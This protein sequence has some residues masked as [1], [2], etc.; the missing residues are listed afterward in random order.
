MRIKLLWLLPV[1]LISFSG[2]K[3]LKDIT[4]G[5]SSWKA[6]EKRAL[7]EHLDFTAVTLSGKAR[8]NY[9]EGGFN[10]LGAS[11]RIT[12]L[13]DSVIMIRVIKLI[14]AAR[15]LITQDSIYV[16][17]RI[18]NQ[19]IV[20]DFGLAE[21]AIGLPADFGLIQDLL[22]G[23]YHP[24][25]SKM[26]PVQKRGNPKTFQGVAAGMNFT[27]SL[28]SDLAKPI[29]ILAIDPVAERNVSLAYADFQKSDYG[30][31]PNDGNI[32]VSGAEELSVTFTHR[33]VTFSEDRSLASFDVPS[34]YTKIPCE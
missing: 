3:S 31:Y 25:P 30:I 14:E 15:I 34:G 6:V 19:L 4:A 9:P 12:I 1:I 22:L 7:G 10:N 17:N 32:D 18:S 16:Q 27:Y 28:D 2:C 8:V 5:A 33:K 11:Y 24:I 20:C 21:Q 13:K 23:Q 26:T 29:N